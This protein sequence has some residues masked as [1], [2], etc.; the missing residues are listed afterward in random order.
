MVSDEMSMSTDGGISVGLAL[1]CR[2][3]SCWSTMPS[4]W[5]TSTA[6]PTRLM[7]TSALMSSSRLTMR[8]STWVTVLRTGWCWM[9]RARVSRSLPSTLSDSRVL[10]PASPDMA[11]WNSRATTATG[12]GSDPWPYT[13]PGILPSVRR[14][15]VELDPISRPVW[16]VSVAS[17]MRGLLG[18]YADGRRATPVGSCPGHGP[19]SD[20][21]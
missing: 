15:R 2:V 1:M 18:R 10:S 19:D 21:C 4:P 20:R 5:A 3:K 7:V 17:D 13:T 11:I 6:S 8:K 14:R 16:A 12:I 9:S